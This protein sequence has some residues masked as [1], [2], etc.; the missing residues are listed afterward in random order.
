[1]YRFIIALVYFCA[2]NVNIVG[3]PQSKQLLGTRHHIWLILAV[4]WRLTLSNALEKSKTWTSVSLPWSTLYMCQWLVRWVEAH[5]HGLPWI[6]TEYCGWC[7]WVCHT[8]MFAAGWWR[9][10]N[11]LTGEAWKAGRSVVFCRVVLT[12]LVNW[13]IRLDP[14]IHGNNL[15]LPRELWNR[16][17]GF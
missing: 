16:W 5:I 3:I 17:S 15:P 11:D 12:L 6:H 9:M 10:L 13:G 1:M 14:L 2:I 8:R 7:C 4:V